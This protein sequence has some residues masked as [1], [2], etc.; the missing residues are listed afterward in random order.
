[1]RPKERIPIFLENVNWERLAKR[2]KVDI[3]AFNYIRLSDKSTLKEITNYWNENS[4][5]RFGQ[6]LINLGLIADT[7]ITWNDEELNILLDQGCKP[8]NVILWGRNF[9]KAG[10]RLPKTEWILIKNLETDHIEAILKTQ[11]LNLNADYIKIFK[12]ELKLRK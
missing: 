8:R 9:N 6:V 1:M 7:L 2:W 11:F 12:D 3:S 5:Q 10:E 4:D